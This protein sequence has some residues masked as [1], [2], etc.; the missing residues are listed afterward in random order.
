MRKYIWIFILFSFSVRSFELEVDSE[1]S[2]IERLEDHDQ[3]FKKITLTI[4]QMQNELNGTKEKI[5]ELEKKIIEIN[6]E[7]IQNTKLVQD[8]ANQIQI[9]K[10]DLAALKESKEIN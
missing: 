6:N 7:K 10:K 8:Q 9:L 5:V 2:K 3:H 4:N 1:K